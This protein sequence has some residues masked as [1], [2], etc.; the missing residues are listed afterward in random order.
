MSE[1][2]SDGQGDGL[3]STLATEPS[4]WKFVLSNYHYYLTDKTYGNV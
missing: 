4:L 2:Q 3:P 1:L